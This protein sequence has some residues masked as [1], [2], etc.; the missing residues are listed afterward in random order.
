V[1]QVEGLSIAHNSHYLFD[2]ATF[3][4]Q[5]G[6]RCGLVGR[7]GSGKS[8]LLKLL[9]GLETADSGTVTM[10]KGYTVATLEQHIAFRGE[11]ILQEAL[12]GL[13]EELSAQ[14]YKAE[15]ILA[16]L[17]FGESELSKSPTQL[18]GGYQLRL[19]L[20]KALLLEPDCLLLDEPTNYLD[21]ISMRW[22]SQMLRQWRGELIIVSHDREFMDSVTTHTMGI[23]RQKIRKIKGTTLDLFEKI[24]Q[25][26]EIYQKTVDNLEKKRS[27]LQG[28]ID[29]FGAKAT[30]AA[31]ARSKQK[32]LQR[33]PS[34]EALKSLY[35]LDF[36]FN[37]SPFNG[38]K[39]IDIEKISFGYSPERIIVQG[40]TLSI[41]KGERIAIIGKNGRGKSTLLRL[42]AQELTPQ[43][44]RLQYAENVRLGYFG[45]TNIS[46]LHKQHTIVEEVTAANPLLSYSEIKRICGLMMFSGD[47]ADKSISVLS[48][49]EKSRVLLGKILAAPCNM[50]LLDEPTHHLDMESVESLVDALEEFEGALLL[51][52]HSE[53]MLKRIAFDKILFCSD[54]GIEIFLGDYEDFLQKGG[55]DESPPQVEEPKRKVRDQREIKQLRAELINGRSKALKPLN[56]AIAKIEEE[57]QRLESA[58]QEAHMVLAVV[59]PLPPG[60]SPQDIAKLAA[61]QQQQVDSYYGELEILL[62]CREETEKAFAQQLEEL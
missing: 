19:H 47:K 29:R 13:P 48:G 20:A 56:S 21:I 43:G 3:A 26:E 62:D 55:W 31:Q 24:C 25:E 11:T 10:R 16:G 23:H 33:I 40:I 30:K 49:G 1:I 37:E 54:S 8:T 27:H 38:K 17:G 6:E 46:R 57:L 50:L 36:Q 52:T 41:E 59:K 35:Q 22:L 12:C 42:I 51:V 58:I 60:S 34:L 9:T 45:Q 4:I 32:M 14:S 2:E 39:M 28:F 5:T 15:K 18:S 44:G 53:L 7:N 61:K